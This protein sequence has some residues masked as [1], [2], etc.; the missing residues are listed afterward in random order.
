MF[1][2][3]DSCLFQSYPKNCHINGLSSVWMNSD[4]LV[5][6]LLSVLGHKI[7]VFNLGSKIFIS[8]TWLL[9]KLQG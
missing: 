9:A 6:V 3:Q 1:L 8:R 7:L 5:Y 2:C 4:Q